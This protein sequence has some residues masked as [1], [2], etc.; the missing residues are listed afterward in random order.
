MIKQAIK[1]LWT[2]FLQWGI[3]KVST[4]VF[5]LKKSEAIGLCQQY[6]CKYYVIQQGYWKWQVLRAGA[7]DQYKR[8]GFINKNVTAIELAKLAAFIADPKT[9]KKK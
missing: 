4:W 8:L 3:N 2:A 1:G 9:Y 7:V 6:G 5:N